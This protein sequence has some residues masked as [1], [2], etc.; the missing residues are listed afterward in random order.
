MTKPEPHEFGITAEQIHIYRTATIA[1]PSWVARIS[2]YYFMLAGAG[3]GF[4]GT[5]LTTDSIESALGGGLAGFLVG[6]PALFG[7]MHVAFELL[8]GGLTR[9]SRNALLSGLTRARIEQFEKSETL[10]YKT[11]QEEE[12]RKAEIQQQEVH[13]RAEI[14]ESRRKV[15]EARRREEQAQ[16][17]REEQARRQKLTDYWIRL[18]PLRFE[19]ELGGL[20]KQLGYSVQLTPQSGDH[21]VDLV[22]RKNGKTTVVQCKRQRVLIIIVTLWYSVL[23]HQCGHHNLSV[24]PLFRIR[25]RNVSGKMQMRRNGGSC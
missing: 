25:I 21:G 14:H 7:L 11:E 15:E 2:V 19:R 1:P 23:I 9:L 20:Y 16:R 8:C 13:R 4:F 17:Q 22:L 5:L 18:E 6:G 3:V 12:A 24:L 10:Y